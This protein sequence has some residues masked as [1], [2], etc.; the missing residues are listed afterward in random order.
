[1]KAKCNRKQFQTGGRIAETK[2]DDIS[3]MVK[4]PQVHIGITD[5]V[6]IEKKLLQ[7]LCS[8]ACSP[9][10]QCMGICKQ[11]MAPMTFGNLPI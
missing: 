6:L 1:M 5:C 4:I 11:S 3:Q 8:S 9:E 7:F 10:G 2:L